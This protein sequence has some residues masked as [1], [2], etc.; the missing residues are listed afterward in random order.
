MMQCLWCSDDAEEIDAHG[1]CKRCA[2]PRTYPVNC[3]WCDAQVGVSPVEHSTGMC[4]VCL[5]L[6]YPEEAA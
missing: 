1:A 2:V 4:R 5:E 3:G 6:H